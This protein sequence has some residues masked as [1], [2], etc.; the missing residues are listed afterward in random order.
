[1]TVVEGGPEILSGGV[2][3]Q[4]EA[5]RRLAAALRAWDYYQVSPDCLRTHP[6]GTGGT[7]YVFDVVSMGCGFFPAGETLGRWRIDARTGAVSLRNGFGRFV[8]PS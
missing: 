4:P 8:R 2:I 6:A 7:D 3:D 5:A 1:M